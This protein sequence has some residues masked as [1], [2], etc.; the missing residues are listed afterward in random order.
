[1]VPN[2]YF[3]CMM[4]GMFPLYVWLQTEKYSSDEMSLIKHVKL[5]VKTGHTCDVFWPRY[6]LCVSGLLWTTY[7][8]GV[9]SF[10]W[11]TSSVSKAK[12]GT[13]HLAVCTFSIYNNFVAFKRASNPFM[14]Q[15]FCI[16][17]RLASYILI[18][19]DLRKVCKRALRGQTKSAN[20]SFQAIVRNMYCQQQWPLEIPHGCGFVYDFHDYHS[21][22]NPIYLREL[23]R[24]IELCDA[25][26]ATIQNV[27][28][29]KVLHAQ[30]DKNSL[31]LVFDF[32]F[33]Y[34]YFKMKVSEDPM[35]LFKT[36]ST[37]FAKSESAFIELMKH[38]C[39]GS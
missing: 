11:P 35:I 34:N 33:D 27:Y 9:F 26:F 25:A 15:Q 22:N 19:D 20:I 21:T 4:L 16:Q 31:G 39:E 29:A 36:C 8:F 2:K 6:D 37:Q 12:L 32:L 30:I 24:S 28:I 5:F 13:I 1:M 18:C 3:G 17:M 7:L 38:I 10:V 14:H 23:N